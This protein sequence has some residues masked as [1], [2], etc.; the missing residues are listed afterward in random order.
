MGI[1]GE[2]KRVLG[3]V[4]FLDAGMSDRYAIFNKW[5][6][7]NYGDAVSPVDFYRELF[8]SGLLQ[9][10][11][12]YGDGKYCAIAVSVP[13]TGK[14]RRYSI[15][16]GLDNLERI[17]N[18]D[19]FTIISPVTYAGKSRKQSNS[20]QLVAVQVDMDGVY[21]RD[22]FP[23]GLANIFHQAK[24]GLIPQPTYCCCS[25]NNVHLYYLLDEPLR[26]FPKV[27]ES[28]N[29]FRTQFI[30]QKLYNGDITTLYKEPQIESATQG[31]R[32]VGSICKDAGK[33]VLAYRTGERISIEELN[34]YVSDEN[35]IR[36]ARPT[37]TIE[38]AKAKYPRW[39]ARVNGQHSRKPWYNSR[40]LFDWWVRE[41]KEKSEPGH[42]YW[43]IVCLA[44]I[45]QKANIS[46][47]ELY[48]TAFSLVDVLDA[49]TIDEKNHFTHQDV[50]KALECYHQPRLMM[51]RESIE[52]LSGI[53]I[54]PNKRN[55]RKR[56]DHLKY[57]RGIKKLR[58]ELGENVLGGRPDKRQLI[59][60]YLKEHPDA[61]QTEIAKGLGISRTTVNKHRRTIQ[62]YE[63]KQTEQLSLPG[64]PM[65]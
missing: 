58:A 11:G 29:R 42:R 45:S 46:E 21:I 24:N 34:K 23:Y 62:A 32:A 16:D 44:C 14:P 1:R 15:T 43:G 20:R 30:G 18:T 33:R 57:M 13:R 59:V 40:A 6:V 10:K 28:L 48:E 4:V 35:R 22:G 60:D 27:I 61:N 25:G 56:A 37:M 17:V 31:M 65:P 52:R 54:P 3:G 51:K 41:L 12:V 26:M 38:E 8:P 5:M 47:D 9:A 55:G 63:Y 64:F 19:D 53:S 50:M 39:Y 2:V 49:K 36:P 7:E